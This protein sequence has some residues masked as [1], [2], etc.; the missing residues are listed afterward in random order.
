MR[1]LATVSLGLLAMFLSVQ[2]ASAQS[3]WYIS[4]SAGV[5]LRSSVTTTGDVSSPSG[6][7]A[8]TVTNT[9]DP[10]PVI[11]AAIGYRLPFGV[12]VEA[13][14]GF[15]H[16]TTASSNPFAPGVPG[17]NGSKLTPSA[18]GGHDRY[19]GTVNAFYDLPISGRYVPYIG[20]GF[21]VAQ[22][23]GGTTYF[24][25]PGTSGRFIVG[26]ASVV[27]PVIL[28][29]V[30]VA[31]ALSDRWSVVPAYRFEHAFQTGA[32]TEN[33]HILKLGLRYAF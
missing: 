18:G 20:G 8:A 9:Y 30:G 1:S 6:R 7:A 3:N 23:N 24:P 28:G 32:N 11:N 25:V 14:A 16:F 29:E 4:G 21:G 10:G 12:R 33:A 19:T 31:I 13:E 15:A 22:L 26:G 2:A 5:Y 27:R 17:L